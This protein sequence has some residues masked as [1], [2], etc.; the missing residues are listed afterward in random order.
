MMIFIQRKITEKSG[1]GS[2]QKIIEFFELSLRKKFNIDFVVKKQPSSPLVYVENNDKY[3]VFTYEISFDTN[4]ESLQKHID[5]EID[6]LCALPKWNKYPFRI[7]SQKD[8]IDPVALAA[9]QVVNA[10]ETSTLITFSETIP[11]DEFSELCL[12][13]VSNIAR[14]TNEE[15]SEHEA[16]KGIF[17]LEAHIRIIAR[18]IKR[19]METDGRVRNHS[20]LYGEPGCGKTTLIKAL[21]DSFPNG[22]YITYSADSATK[23][24]YQKQFMKELQEVGG[25]PP[26][27][28]LEEVDKISDVSSIAPFLSV[29]DRRGIMEKNTA[30]FSGKIDARSLCIVTANDKEKFDAM[31]SGAFASRM[32]KHLHVPLP[33]NE[34]IRRILRREIEEFGGDYEWIEPCMDLAMDLNIH[35]PRTIISFLEGGEGL[36]DYSYQDDIKSV[37][38]PI[39]VEYE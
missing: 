1:E 6:K 20:C 39:P 34:T 10:D 30:R 13:H 11:W 14:A 32:T 15:L 21:L 33:N 29:L 3:Y 7:P 27:L 22:S 26:I 19:A 12:E 2:V 38:Q 8:W 25:I 9:N 24:G 31:L 36:L 37:I 17:N 16:F 18:S 5:E 4:K 35:D 28:A 23:A